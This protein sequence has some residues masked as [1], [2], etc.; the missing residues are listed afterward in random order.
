MI[1][2]KNCGYVFEGNYCSNC[3]QA[4]NTKRLSWG[5]IIHNLEYDIFNFD[6][7]IIYTVGQIFVRP[8]KTIKEYLDGK[9]KKYTPPITYIAV[10]SVIYYIFRS[11]FV[12]DAS[13]A[14]ATGNDKVIADF[15]YNY[16]P[17]LVVFVFIP[18]A[19]VFTPIFYPNRRY[20]FV[21]LFAFHC[22]IRG[23]FMLFE[24]V[25]LLVNWILIKFNIS[26][27]PLFVTIITVLFNLVFMG[28]ALQQFFDE[29]NYLI[30]FAKSVA[31]MALLIVSAVLLTQI[32]IAVLNW[33]H[34][35]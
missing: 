4:A 22:Y 2:C 33:T 6:H 11:I 27:T 18:L 19:T 1:V 17:K 16:Y 14:D 34:T 15:I 3:G 12:K 13:P 21:E 28:W 9:R 5:F 30:N 26:S 35:A 31:L 29:K 20:S 23:Q 25:V 24:M 8:G 7:G 32:A 10:I